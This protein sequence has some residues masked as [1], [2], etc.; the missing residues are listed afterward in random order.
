MTLYTHPV[1]HAEGYQSVPLTYEQRLRSRL[2]LHLGA[3]GAAHI[4]LPRGMRLWSG[5]HVKA[6]DGSVLRIESA[7]EAVSIV[8]GTGM[9][10]AR[11]TYHL[12][13]R[14]IPAAIREGSV[15][16][17]K[18]PVIDDL[19]KELGFDVTHGNQPFEPEIGPVASR[20][21]EFRRTG[22]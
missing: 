13:H 6:D 15:S 2:F 18:D 14:Q 8:K 11:A 21:H 16:Y 22:P 4:I 3:R 5:L 7:G 10:L 9:D 12:G 17:Q 20:D 19:M 1:S